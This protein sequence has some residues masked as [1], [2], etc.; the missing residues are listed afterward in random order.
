MF[1]V[2]PDEVSQLNDVDLRELVGRLCEAE[3]ASRGLST[4]AVTW[5]GSQT[6]AD[7]GLDVR[8]ALSAGI[9]IDGHIPSP[10]TGFQVKTPDM[11]R[12]A[13]LAEMRPDG[14]IRAVIQ[15]LAGEG[16]AYVIVSSHGSTA[17]TALQNRRKAMREALTGVANAG[18]LLTDFY[19]RTRLASW[20]RQHPGLITWVKEKVGRAFI[21]WRPY[22]SWTGTAEGV[23]AEYLLDDKLRIHLGWQPDASARPIADAID[24]LRDVLA[25]PRKLVRLVGLSGVGKTRLVE[26]L[27]D[28]RIGLRPLPPSLAVY[29][30]LSDNPTPQPT[31]L[32]SDLIANR[33]RAILIV[34]NCPP[35]LHRRLSD[36]CVARESTVSVLTVEYDVR[37]DQPEGTQ[38]VTLETSSPELIKKLIRR[39]FAHLS[40]VD[41]RTIADASGGNA[42]IALAI[43][44]TIKHSETVAGLSDDDLF[45][46]LF[47]QRHDPNDAL[48]RAAQAC[49]L[50]YSFQGVALAG[51]EAELPRLA[52]LADQEPRELYR[53]V[54]EL[55][56]RDL[57]QKRSVWRA[58]LPH[59]I[60]NRLAVRALEETPDDLIDQQLV[61]DGTDRLARSFSRR[62]AFLHDHPR[63][64]AIVNRWL[65]PGGLLGE[66]AALNDLGKAMFENVAPVVPGA[67]LAALERAC[68]SDAGVASMV[69]NQHRSLLRSLA[70]DPLLFGRSV[71]VMAQAYGQITNARE[72]KQ[73]ADTFVSLFKIHL[74]GTHATIEQRLAVIEKLLRSSELKQ[75]VLGLASFDAVLETRHFGS[76][77][78][79]EF[80]A[81]S[82]DYG[83]QPRRGGDVTRWYSAALALI[84]RL[85]LTEGVLKLELKELLMRHFR[86]LWS[87]S[88]LLEELER[89][90]RRFA[91]DGFWREGWTACRQALHFDKDSLSLNASSRLAALE[92]ELRPTNLTERI[93]A[94]VLGDSLGSL[95]MEDVEGDFTSEFERREAVAQ[96]LGASVAAND[97]AFADLMPDLL[98][99]G[100]RTWSFGYGLAGAA[101]DIRA[102]WLRLVDGLGQLPLENRNIRVLLGFFTKL[103]EG[104]S[105]L[106]NDLLDATFDQPALTAFVPVLQSVRQIDARGVERLKRALNSSQVPVWMYQNLAFGKTTDELAGS[107]LRDLL[108]LISQRSGGFNVAL[109]ILYMRLYSDNIAQRRHEP[110][111][112]EAGQALVRRYTFTRGNQS[113]D[114]QLSK[115]VRACLTGPTAAACA[116]EVA[117]GLKR[118]VAAYETYSFDNDGLM[119]ALLAVQP[120]PVLDALF[121][122][123]EQ[124]QRDGLHMFDHLAGLRSNPADEISCENLIA[125]CDQDHERRYLLAASFVTFSRQ[126]ESGPLIW[127]EQAKAL[128]A[129]AANAEGV[130]AKFIDRFRPTSWSGSRAALMEA[131]ACL[132]DSLE[133]EVTANLASIVTAAKA[134]L[135]RD[136]ESERERETAQDRVQD[137]RFE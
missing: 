82:R 40:G 75:Q 67:A 117:G 47:R 137:E 90:V 125:W 19:D 118:A 9:A 129:H 88:D 101:E 95:D 105:E 79:F 68:G 103:W 78:S 57:V 62:L 127:S 93:R 107:D 130:L 136:V 38:V 122:G 77:H 17:D 43:A 109:T 63:A 76:G 52:V 124:A 131:N 134:Q 3:L 13:I 44:G 98:R 10:S 74:S 58:V 23:E 55:L 114:D 112:L 99:G 21:G 32:A 97:A 22:G 94:V 119:S 8:V 14:A 84:E 2:K 30:N 20:V 50:V 51:D 39:R 28:A 15:N 5:G 26:A 60:A 41:A 66:T 61:T 25:E 49:S 128:L 111:L 6:A 92:A 81:R 48:L 37:D 80:G 121:N 85:A 65:A 123:D 73:A 115:V 86:G 1:D 104:D 11:A 91:V 70:Y 29:T 33:T 53:H 64:V 132:L 135:A 89:L 12:A 56:R 36:L 46:R 24:V 16:G 18:Q 87:L 120:S 71:S 42:R 69:A 59:A 4:V 83:Y 110:E 133:S 7:G 116:G 27:F 106:A 45:Q 102:T 108:Q 54:S 113:H 72:A 126:T 31:G 35:D 96:E 34:D 100:I